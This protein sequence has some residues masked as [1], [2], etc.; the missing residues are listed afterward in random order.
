MRRKSAS[1][2]ANWDKEQAA[3]GAAWG[4]EK[5]R[6]TYSPSI[7]TARIKLFATGL[8]NCSGMTLQPGTGRLWCVVNERD[9]LGDNLP[10]DY[11]TH[12]A[13]GRLLRLA[14]VLHRLERGSAARRANGPTSPAR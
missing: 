6:R 13:G 1:D 9:A 5:E 7:P 14:L 3:I 8:R 11:A 4:D 12:V 2:A 10:P